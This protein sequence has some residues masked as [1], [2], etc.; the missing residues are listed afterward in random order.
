MAEYAQYKATF[1]ELVELGEITHHNLKQLKI[2]NSVTLPLSYQENF[3]KGVPD[4]G[5]LARFAYFKDIV[6]GAVCAKI[7]QTKDTRTLYIMT[8]AVLGAYRRLG[9]AT[10]LLQHLLSYCEGKKFD[11]IALHVQT[12]NNEAIEFYE[13]FGFK[14]I[15]TVPS[16]YK[17][18]EPSDAFLLNKSLKG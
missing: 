12:N 7:D 4:L 11:E 3:Y 10:K 8:L 15:K 6:V 2:L 1:K 9:V 16:Y 13:R 14:V 5:E 18:I 17:R